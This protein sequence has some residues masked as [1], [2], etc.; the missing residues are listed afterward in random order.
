LETAVARVVLAVPSLTVGIVGQD[1]S[2]PQFVQCSSINL[3][4]HL[5]YLEKKGGDPGT[6]DTTLLG[7]LE[8]QHDRSWPEIEQRP[9]WKLTVVTRDFAPEDG[10]V[11]LDAIF[12]V[13]H[14]VA[15]GRSTALFHTKLLSEL[16]RSPVR[17]VQLVGH[18]LDVK[19]AGKLVQPQEELVK[20]SISWRF[21]VQT[22]WR[23]LGPAWLQ[24]QPPAVPWTG[25]AITR[26]PC[27]TRLRLVTVP[28][29]AVP[30]ILA[31]CRE[32]QTT[33]TPLLHAL[34]LASLARQLPP[35]DAVAFGSSTPIDLR[36]FIDSS[37]QPSGSRDTFG[38]LVTSQFHQFG[39][40]TIAQLRA[41]PSIDEIWRVAADLRGSMKQHLSNIPNDDVMGLLR[42]VSDWKTFWLSKV[43]KPR[44][45]TWEVSNIGSLPGGHGE[46][47]GMTGGWRIERSFM[48][49]GATVAGAAIGI[50]V[51]GVAGGEISMVLGW[52][53]DVVKT[54]MVECLAR[55]LED[56]LG[57]LGGG[58]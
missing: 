23:E 52:Q 30:G 40:S 7:I 56:W 33:L 3:E 53:E 32:N 26:A 22:L 27:R 38:V 31:A 29:T 16:N 2:S 18:V 57:Q 42:W 21:L 5:E 6:Q 8:D 28:A 51:A 36:P 37:S 55:D 43:G 49:Q 58:Q 12:A 47:E 10:L 17:P 46:A 15:D 54:E 14:A 50:S 39:A 48:S 24:R 20:F 13:H 25:E 11:V 19:G 41:G 9:P 35:E 1:T 45:D 44:Q 34:A 4:H